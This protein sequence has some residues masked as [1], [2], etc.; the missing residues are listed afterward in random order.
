MR[1][2]CN[3]TVDSEHLQTS[4]QSSSKVSGSYRLDQAGYSALD[5]LRAM[6]VCTNWIWYRA[7]C[8]VDL[9]KELEMNGY[10]N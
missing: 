2:S 9:V 6:S 10:L 7:Q 8:G 3:Y 4:G 1:L 5:D